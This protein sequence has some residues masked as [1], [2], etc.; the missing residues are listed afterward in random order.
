MMAMRLASNGRFRSTAAAHARSAAA[1]TGYVRAP[2][3]TAV[4][5]RIAFPPLTHFA[6]VVL[7]CFAISA[8]S[9]RTFGPIAPISY[10]NAILLVALLLHHPRTWPMFAIAV[11]LVD[12][13]ACQIWGDTLAGLLAL[14]D[15]LEAT[16]AATLVR[17]TGGL[18]MP[19]FSGLQVFRVLAVCLLAPLAPS[20]LAAAVYQ[21]EQS[22]PF[23]STWASWYTANTLGLVIA[24]P[25]LLSWADPHLRR[26]AAELTTPRGL[27]MLAAGV[28][29]AVLFALGK[30]GLIFLSFPLMF[31]LTWSAGLLGA[32]IGVAAATAAVLWITIQGEGAIVQMTSEATMHERIQTVQLYLA[33]I[34]LCSLPLNMLHA[35]LTDLA[36]NL[37]RAAEARGDFLAAMSH[38]I[39]TPMTAVLGVLDLLS[40]ERLTSVQQQYVGMMRS[41]GLHLLNIINDVL[42]FTRIESGK[43]ALEEIDFSLRETLES[44][45]S[46]MNPLAVDRGLALHID[47]S[48]WDVDLLRGDPLRLRQVL[49]NLVSNAIKF[50]EHGTVTVKLAQ[51][52]SE[53]ISGVRMRFSVHDTGMG[54]A[55]EKLALLFAPFTQADRSISRQFGGSGLGLAISKRLV[56]AMGGRIE[57]TSVVGRG[58]VFSFE[59]PFAVGD[60][61]RVQGASSPLQV[62]APMRRILVAEDVDV[63]R[64]ILRTV[65]TRHGHEVSFAVDGRQ[66]VELIQQQPFDLVLMDVQMPVMDGVEATR[67]IRKLPPPLNEIPILGLTANVMAREREAYL[68]AGMNACLSKPIDWNEMHAA[69]AHHG[70]SAPNEV[71][72]AQAAA[73]LETEDDGEGAVL[74]AEQLERLM[75]LAGDQAPDLIA[76]G[77]DGQATSCERMLVPGATVEVI[78]QE[79]HK[80]KG[81]AGTLGLVAL[82]RLAAEI[83]AIARQGER[84]EHLLQELRPTLARTR[85]EI[86][87]RRLLQPV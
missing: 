15:V 46:L 35:R 85:A 53:D 48:G 32:T 18:R 26:Q 70:G 66:A 16:L 71:R 79:S 36:A 69:I 10:C 76:T 82:A 38:E 25:F 42:D 28:A 59:L 23:F 11:W 50:T 57:A 17:V 83:E 22:A 86:A 72:S 49:L 62:Q 56:E 2:A 20:A 87:R 1:P 60:A 68:A 41:A 58:S 45:R 9:V 27:L 7:S 63:N 34:L 78:H 13:L 84:P 64:E 24:C 19:L 8:L 3:Q 81:S 47:T 14:S 74:D 80:I 43:L 4:L 77:L 29:L 75:Q 39:R 65:L 67:R 37:R 6:A 44:L 52:R 73:P 51:Q 33:A 54:I 12:F 55:P 5:V 30:A 21:A 31:A 40:A 61:S